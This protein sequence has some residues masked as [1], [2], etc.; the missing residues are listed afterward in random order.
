LKIIYALLLPA[1]SLSQLAPSM[2]KIAEGKA[3]AAKIFYI[4]DREPKIKSKDKAII[5]ETF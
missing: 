4:I 5:P 1:L 3:A 2:Q